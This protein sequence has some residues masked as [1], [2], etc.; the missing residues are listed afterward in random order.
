[1]APNASVFEN[2]SNKHKNH[3]GEAL[4]N[5]VMIEYDNQNCYRC[6]NYGCHFFVDFSSIS[7]HIY[8]SYESHRKHIKNSLRS[9]KIKN[10]FSEIIHFAYN[11]ACN[12]YDSY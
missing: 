2:E 10:G 11:Q 5:K 8:I 12:A 9:H 7:S 6:I 3:D 1:L 4:K